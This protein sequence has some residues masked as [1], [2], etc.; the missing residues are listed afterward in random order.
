[1]NAS[2]ATAQVCAGT[3]D[4]FLDWHGRAVAIIASGPSAKKANVAALRGKIPVIAIKENVE[5]APWADIAY[6]CDAAWW[7]NTRGLPDFKGL[8]VSWKGDN[9]HPPADYPDIHRIDITINSDELIF[10]PNGIVGSGGN[11]GYQALN[12]AVQFGANRILLIGFDM[13]DRSGLHWYGRN[14]GN[15]RNNPSQDSFRRWRLAFERAAPKL[16]AHGVE[17]VNA[18]ENSAL[19]CFERRKVEETLSHWND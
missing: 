14:R 12:L 15:G 4:W 16:K 3:P 2:Q 9:S 8:K 10:E 7:K 5:L 11:S 1:M 6:G 17:I 18:S 13:H 19:A